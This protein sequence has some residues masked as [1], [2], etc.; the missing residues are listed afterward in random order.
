MVA[1]KSHSPLFLIIAMLAGL[2]AAK[3]WM[4]FSQ[5]LVDTIQVNSIAVLATI[6]YALVYLPLLV[7]AL[8]LG[9]VCA[10]KPWL[11][12][13][14]A[15]KWISIGLTAGLCGM[16]IAALL[17]RLNGGMA[18]AVEAAQ[19]SGGLLAIGGLLTLFQVLVEELLFRGWLRQTFR[20]MLG[21]RNAIVVSALTYAAFSIVGSGFALLPFV[22]LVLLALFLGLL[23]ERSGGIAAPVAAH[24]SWSA[25]EDIGLGLNP[26]PGVG[27]FGAI[28][29]F[30]LLGA[31][32][33]GGSVAG[34]AASIGTA[35]VLAALILPL[36]T[37]SAQA[38]V[39][40]D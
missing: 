20:A 31:P 8:V 11:T 30:D 28:R 19:T 2:A 1:V 25:I 9:S 38:G 5:P 7:L 6:Y 32:L 29:D 33:W 4:H 40:A 35:A 26:N 39:A 23:A 36:L 14:N 34:L 12:G 21:P 16:G 13:S 27:P 37:T 17:A 15:T 22:N 18:P 10:V 3:G 24:F